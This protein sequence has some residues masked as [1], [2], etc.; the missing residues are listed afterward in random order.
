MPE[1]SSHSDLSIETL[2]SLRVQQ[3]FA[4]LGILGRE[5][6]ANIVC[7]THEDS[8]AIWQAV[9]GYQNAYKATTQKFRGN[10]QLAAAHAAQELGVQDGTDF[11][12]V[13][14]GIKPAARLPRT[15][16]RAEARP[17]GALPNVGFVPLFDEETYPDPQMPGYFFNLHG[18][19]KI[20]EQ[21]RDLFNR[22][23]YDS[24]D[25]REVA[26]AVFN[27]RSPIGTSLLLGHSLE[28]AL[29]GDIARL[30]DE[31]PPYAEVKLFGRDVIR[32]FG[33]DS[34]QTAI[35]EQLLDEPEAIETLDLLHNDPDVSYVAKKI[36]QATG[37]TDF[38]QTERTNTFG[39][40]PDE[41][42]ATAL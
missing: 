4:D 9:R 33:L 28:Q 11:R 36:W 29:F 19:N 13:T 25:A 6:Y 27:D 32:L 23:G 38:L 17:D 8:N 30:A 7:A 5:S 2:N 14:I 3:E 39:A 1:K 22:L 21:H 37:M 18:V 16:L 20:L 34:P 42:R 26:A 41:P 40:L 24:A 12:L 10:E 35:I 15:F 31:Q